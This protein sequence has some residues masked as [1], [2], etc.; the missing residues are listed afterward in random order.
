V[1]ENKLV[2]LLKYGLM[3]KSKLTGIF[4]SAKKYSIIINLKKVLGLFQKQRKNYEFYLFGWISIVLPL[5]VNLRP[6]GFPSKSKIGFGIL[7]TILFL[8][9]NVSLTPNSFS[10]FFQR[11]NDLIR[12]Y[13]YKRLRTYTKQ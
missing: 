5:I 1:V 2:N 3:V 8:P 9:S 12:K 4:V 7:H 10:S 6:S 13:R 11:V